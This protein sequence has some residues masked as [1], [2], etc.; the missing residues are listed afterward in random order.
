MPRFNGYEDINRKTFA[1]AINV[2]IAQ[3][4][5]EYC[6]QRKLPMN[7]VLEMF[8]QQFQNGEINLVLKKKENK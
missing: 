3:G 1:T 2:D 5:R 8:M 7:I 4:F 6:K